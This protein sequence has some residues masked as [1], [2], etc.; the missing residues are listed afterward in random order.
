VLEMQVRNTQATNSMLLMPSFFLLRRIEIFS[1][2]NLIDTI[3]PEHNYY[4]SVLD[5]KYEYVAAHRGVW[6]IGDDYGLSTATLA[7]G[8]ARTLF[9]PIPSVITQSKVL[10]RALRTKLRVECHFAAGTDVYQTTSVASTGLVL[11][12]IN[13][14][15]DG[16]RFQGPIL[17]QLLK[18]YDRTAHVARGSVRRYEKLTASSATAGTD[19]NLTLSSLNGTFSHMRFFARP[20]GATRDSLISG[21]QLNTFTILDSNGSP[22]SYQNISGEYNRLEMAAGHV[23]S[24]F[25]SKTG[26]Q[27]FLYQYAFS[28][29]PVSTA[30]EGING[31]EQVLNSNYRLAINVVTG[32][33][34]VRHNLRWCSFLMIAL[35]SWALLL[36]SMA[37]ICLTLYLPSDCGIRYDQLIVWTNLLTIIVGIWIP[38]PKNKDKKEPALLP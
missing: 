8:A 26:A 13:L 32:C 33:F 17:D 5:N 37:M 23:A 1:G 24:D 31:G 4:E 21:R 20:N 36:F 15:M 3:Y 7:A 25:Y 19:T 27:T 16:F 29:D 12:S 22:L 30:A 6:S 11:D 28:D 9:V 35:I 34:G 38:Q 18:S 10:L 14:R 2:S